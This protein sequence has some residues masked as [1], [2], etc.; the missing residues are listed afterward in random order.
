MT[1]S[2]EDMAALQRYGSRLL[3]RAVG[4]ALETFG[5]LPPFTV[6]DLLR[7]T[8]CEGWD[9][10]MLLAHLDDS[11]AALNEAV[12]TGE[13]RLEPPGDAPSAAPGELMGS[14]RTR[15]LRLRRTWADADRDGRTVMVAGCPMRAGVVAGTGAV[16]LVVHAWDAGRAVGAEAAIPADLAGRLLRLAPLL[17]PE[18]AR[19]GLFGPPV[20]VPDGAPPGDRLVAFLGRAP[21]RPGQAGV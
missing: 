18:H 13:I 2:A 16:E 15:A 12:T 3:R 14:L 21:G 20:E 19:E 6:A 5:T 8:P 7:P 9:L 10:W 11:L 4:F 1:A 17:V